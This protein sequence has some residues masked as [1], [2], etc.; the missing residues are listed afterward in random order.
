LNKEQLE[1]AFD[2]KYWDEKF[3]FREEMVPIFLSKY[4][5]KILH[6]GKYLNVMREC[7]LDLQYPYPHHENLFSGK[8][9]NNA[10][11]QEEEAAERMEIDSGAPAS[12]NFDFFEPIDKAYEWSSKLL[13]EHLMGECQ[14]LK[15]LES[16]KHYFFL[17]KGDFF[18]HFVEGSEEILE[19]QVNSMPIEKLESFLEMAIRTSSA[20]ADPFKDDV[21]CSL[22]AFGLIE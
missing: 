9:M 12:R 11:L 20:N 8:F 13:L 17:D 14:L 18:L 3:T 6:A 2:D 4:K 1:K 7:G 22:S 5:E 15:R 21:Y 10:Q 16:L 19:T